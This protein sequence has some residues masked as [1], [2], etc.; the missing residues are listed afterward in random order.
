VEIRTA[1]MNLGVVPGSA[2]MKYEREDEGETSFKVELESVTAGDYP[3][4]VDG[5]QVGTI[6]ASLVNGIVRGKI[7]FEN[8]D[9]GGD[10]HGDDDGELPLN[11]DPL[12]KNIVLQFNG[13]PA[14]ERVLE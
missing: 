10:D 4:L 6:T 2:R 12:G 14:F 5:V 8:D 3:L 11:F 9:D 7:E 13:V 1:L